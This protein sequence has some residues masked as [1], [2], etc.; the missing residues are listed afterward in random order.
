MGAMNAG[1]DFIGNVAILEEK[2]RREYIHKLFFKN[3]VGEVKLDKGLDPNFKKYTP[4]GKM[5]EIFPYG[6]DEG[7]DNILIPFLK[8]LTG[9][10]VYGDTVLKGTGEELTMRWL[11]AYINQE[12]KA[13][14]KRTGKM[15]EQ[16]AKLY[17]LYEEAKPALALWFSRVTNVE[18][19]RAIYEGASANLTA[20]QTVDGVG[21]VKRYH[22]NFYYL[23]A[24]STISAVGTEGKTKT[25]AELNT[26]VTN[27]DTYEICASVLR[28][29]RTKCINLHIPPIYTAD[30]NPFFVLVAHPDQVNNLKA[31][32]DYKTAQRD[33]FTGKMLDS[34]E[35]SG[36]VGYYEGFAIFEE[37]LGAR[38]WDDSNEH[39]F[40]TTIA[41]AFEPTT[42]TDNACALVLGSGAIGIAEPR[43]LHYTN[44]EDDH[45]NIIE[46][47]G[48]RIY[49][50]NRADFGAEDDAG[51]ESG[52]L[53]YILSA[54]GVAS[55][56][57]CKNQSSLILMTDEN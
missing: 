18:F 38:G 43:K 22:P 26:A 50:I 12:R 30:G 36:A 17:K 7:R 45:G 11:R 56:L 34:P 44:E 1:H 2:L 10:P 19:F 23:S 14:I 20:A 39:F 48:A 5:V 49:G 13:V 35:L 9:E 40:G 51:E 15:A 3:W 41:T 4:S 42:I 52:D 6:K 32:S 55:A 57:T 27:V 8:N 21:L 31:D 47:G 29:L 54:G 24:A 53:F 33:A 46:I 16:R 25:A 37:Y 28:K